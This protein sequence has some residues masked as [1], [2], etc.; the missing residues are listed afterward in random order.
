MKSTHVA[1]AMAIALAAALAAGCSST[2]SDDHQRPELRAALDASSITLVESV[3]VALAETT[4]GKAFEAAL[5]VEAA[6][7]FAVG[8]V[9]QAA[10]KEFRISG[11][12]G[13]VVGSTP[14]NGTAPGACPGQ[15]SLTA[16][17]DIAAATASGDAVAVVPDDDVECAFEIQVLSGETLWEVKVA[18]DGAVLEHEPPH[19]YN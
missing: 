5:V 16:A 19:E 13:Q 1:V 6:P 7:M 17:L 18:G 9:D 2:E 14:M 12:S 15:I 11:S 10:L 8:A 3:D 4:G